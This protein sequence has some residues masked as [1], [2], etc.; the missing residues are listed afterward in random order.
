[1]EGLP[2]VTPRLGG[3]YDF[4]ERGGKVMTPLEEKRIIAQAVEVESRVSCSLCC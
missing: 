1:M 3:M 2:D 4:R